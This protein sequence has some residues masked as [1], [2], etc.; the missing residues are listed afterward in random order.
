MKSNALLTSQDGCVK[1]SL[2]AAGLSEE[3]A[4]WEIDKEKKGNSNKR[5]WGKCLF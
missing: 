1:V 2:F 5:E 4:Q 3:A